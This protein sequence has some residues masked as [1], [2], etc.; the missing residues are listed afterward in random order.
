[1]AFYLVNQLRG[2]A[3]KMQSPDVV[4]GVAEAKGKTAYALAHNLGLGGACVVTIFKRPSFWQAGG[5][6]GR[7]R[8]G[9][10]HAVEVSLLVP[11]LS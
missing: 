9:Y 1:M 3:G 7:T 10:N 6:D 2:W 8:L 5:I 11:T 4:P